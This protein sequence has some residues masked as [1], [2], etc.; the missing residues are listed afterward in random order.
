MPKTVKHAADACRGWPQLMGALQMGSE[1]SLRRYSQAAVSHYC[2]KNKRR[3]GQVL[4]W[5]N[6]MCA[7][8][9]NLASGKLFVS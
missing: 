8:V 7:L 1:L 6:T 9:N 4:D 5:L 3:Y 2:G